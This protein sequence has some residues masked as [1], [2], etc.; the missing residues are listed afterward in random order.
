MIRSAMSRPIACERH[1]QGLARYLAGGRSEEHTSELQSRLHLGCRL[2]LEKKKTKKESKVK[3][4]EITTMEDAIYHDDLIA[5]DLDEELFDVISLYILTQ[6][7][8][9]AL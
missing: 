6:H 5:I 2:L 8:I 9:S 3:Y 4:C 1:R 7:D